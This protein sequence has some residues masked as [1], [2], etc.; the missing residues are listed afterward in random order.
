VSA[1][2]PA[3]HE[4]P[5]LGRR[6]LFAGVAGYGWAAALQLIATPILLKLLGPESFG[7]VGFYMAAQGV[8]QIFD[9][10]LSPTINREMA[11]ASVERG[12]RAEEARDF[13]RTV[14][15]GYL[16]V[17]VLVGLLVALLAPMLASHW[18][19]TSG[20][21]AA[22]IRTDVALIGLLIA[23]QWPI[24]LY[25]GA[26]TGLHRIATLHAIGIV[27]R[28]AG[29]ATG[30][31][32][33]YFGPRELSGYLLSLAAASFIHVLV[34][35]RLL[36]RALPAA[37]RP[38]RWSPAV[39]YR[40]WRFAAGLS[41]MMVL[42]A[43]LMHGDK[44]LLSRLL[45]LRTY[46]YYM[47][48]SVAGSGLYVF[49]TPVFNV[50]FPALSN[51]VAAGDVAGERETYRLGVQAIA[52]LAI[53]AAA[54]VAFFARDLLLVWTGSAETAQAAAPV[55]RL[56]VVG[57]ALNGLMNAP[58]AL[59]LAHGQT[60]L[61]ISIHIGLILAFLPAVAIATSLYGPLGAAAVWVAVN[62][63]YLAVGV[64]LTHSLLMPGERGGRLAMEV[65]GAS[66]AGIIVVA[67]GR[68]LLDRLALSPVATVA[69]AVL[70]L[71]AAWLA[72]ALMAPRVRDWLRRAPSAPHPAGAGFDR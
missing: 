40:V 19:G 28:G 30:L 71:I 59:Q 50:L 14:E 44:L 41:T 57:T 39:V 10:G 27:M 26:L 43:V 8:S 69:G 6:N 31:L 46:G 36:R 22:A 63:L 68:L 1:D 47:L 2:G 11:R 67:L 5:T 72:A 62:V 51:R 48:A 4:R 25:E 16:L 12:G 38:A 33:L 15:P 32:V 3:H 18:V 70:T 17:G 34:L 13:L 23:V 42:G 53:P 24:T 66:A 45:P 52:V 55:V 58:Y 61:G 35:A 65:A 20:L 9:L 7:L 64:P 56:L 21:S 37:Q 60:R 29:V 49:I 54:L